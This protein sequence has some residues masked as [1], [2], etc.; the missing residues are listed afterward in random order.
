MILNE[1]QLN[2][3]PPDFLFP[4]CPF[5]KKKARDAGFSSISVNF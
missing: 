5:N 4:G 3:W 1:M 2:Q